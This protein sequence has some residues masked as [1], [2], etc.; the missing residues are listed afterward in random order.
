MGT[1]LLSIGITGLNAAQ[2]GILTTGH[3]IANAST[4]GYSRQQIQQSTNIPELTSGG[5]IGQGTNV[6]TVTRSYNQY[7][8]LQ[9]LGSQ[10]NAA[11]MSAYQAQIS[12]IDN[13]LADPT[14]G[15]S[16]A[17]AAFF[18]GVA[19]A[20]A[21][22][23]SVAGRQS[24]IA[25]GQALA[26]RFQG[27]DKRLTE[28]RDGTNAQIGSEVTT[29]N[30]L[31]A[32]L[33]DVNQRII[34]S[35]AVS[36]TQPANDLLDQRDQLINKLNKEVRVSTTIQGDGTLSVFIGNGQ[37]LLVGTQ[38]SIMQA[39]PDPADPQ[40][41]AV[42]FKIP[43][44]ASVVL[45]D[46][47]IT[48][49]NLGG[50]VS[51]RDVSLD[52]AQ[53]ALGR[54]ATG[55][56]TAFNQQH[57]LGQD[58]N[59]TLGGAF[60]TVDTPTVFANSLNTSGAVPT[61]SIASVAALTGSDYL[62]TNDGANNFTLHRLSDGTSTALVAAPQTVDGVS[63]DVTPLAGA[64]A[65]ESWLIEPTRYGAR[66]IGVAITDPNAV[67]LATP[68]RTTIS[69]SN[70]GDATIDSGTVT[71]TASAPL[72]STAN[73]A[74]PPIKIVF[75]SAND[76]TIWD[77][78]LPAAPVVLEAAIPY[79]SGAAVFPTPGALDYGYRIKIN[80]T[81]QAGDTFNVDANLN[82]VSD[83][84]NGLA[85][86]QL[87]TKNLLGAQP[88]GQPTA[89]LQTAYSQLVSQIG[90]KMNEVQV[91]GDA[92]QTLADQAQTARDSFSAV[93][94]DEEAANLLKYQQAY[95][96]S[97]RMMTTANKLFDTILQI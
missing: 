2:A 37:P 62:L 88:G 85:L 50:L 76:Y 10:T 3:N 54:I 35:Q 97:A 28:I 52:A 6:D 69:A 46:S 25:Q 32:Q 31:A 94:L 58:L 21:N 56:A 17:L 41:T 60:F 80:G 68:I 26:A 4:P 65:A 7:L 34:A 18:K 33:A 72:A 22:P 12:Q 45:A 93:N 8:N 96:A 42:A 24:M 47:L 1:S 82:G 84:R 95:Q 48:G 36:S 75:N 67:A 55:L 23:T 74:N 83:N 16:P 73:A 61:L 38:A 64:G 49:G 19:D 27:L 20:T 43:G 11:E 77:N 51:F 92:Q 63:I 87:Q 81:P 66:N 9:V 30:S 90:S 78:T 70:T 79:V 44:S 86:G 29:I 13:L 40:K 89:T 59:G 5:Y 53:N 91:T 71:S 57:Q 39:V 15:L 14:A